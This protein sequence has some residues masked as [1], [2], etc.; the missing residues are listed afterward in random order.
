MVVK[1][2]LHPMIIG[3][4]G[5]TIQNLR[6]K[7]GV[8]VNMPLRNENNKT[9][10]ITIVG[11][12]Q[13]AESARDEIQEIVQKLVSFFLNFLYITFKQVTMLS[14]LILYL[15]QENLYKE[16]IHIDRRF[17]P[18]LIGLG[19]CNILQIKKK[20]HVDIRFLKFYT[21]NSDLVIVY[22]DENGTEDDVLN[23]IDHLKCI[24]EDFVS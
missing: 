10:I 7:Y 16:E 6:N 9:N 22:A 14:N 24:Q 11:Y 18:K 2:E 12:K 23:C 3:K 17:V 8:Q 13:S 19:G 4:K 5:E 15:I 20:Y 21:E 1:P